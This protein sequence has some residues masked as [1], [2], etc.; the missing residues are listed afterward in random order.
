MNV[1]HQ[2]IAALQMF[3]H[4]TRHTVVKE[5]QPVV[6]SPQEEEDLQAAA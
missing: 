4:R 2:Y 6:T 5:P 3:F 1:Y